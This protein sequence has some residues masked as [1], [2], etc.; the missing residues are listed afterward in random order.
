MTPRVVVV[1][2]CNIDLVARCER[3]PRAGETVLARSLELIVGGKGANQAIAAARA[4]ARCTLIGAVGDDTY[5]GQIRE[6][7]RGSGVHIEQLRMEVGTSGVALIAVDEA[8][9]NSIVVVPGANGGLR[10]LTPED[11]AV[12][13]DA[14]AVVFQLEIPIETVI[15]AASAARG[16]RVLNAA[17]ARALPSELL[18]AIDLLVVNEE[19]ARIVAPGATDVDRSLDLLVDLVPRVA[20]TRGASGVRYATRSGERIAIAPPP[21]KAIDATAAGDAFTGMLATALAEGRPAQQA[22]ELA[23]SAG[24]ITV[25]RVGASSAIPARAEIDA[26]WTATYGPVSAR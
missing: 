4:G 21:A 20:L 14:D 13:A 12:I 8:G 11:I 15:A 9:E 17:P 6:V 5:G 19:E 7:L 2:S 1:G 22:L 25:E 24:S 23:S 10:D 16:L 26:R 18:R 3:L